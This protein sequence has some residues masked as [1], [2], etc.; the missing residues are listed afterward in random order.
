MAVTLPSDVTGVLQAVALASVITDV[1]TT[2]LP[3]ALLVRSLPPP[4]AAPFS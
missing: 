3:P 4:A 1:V 2:W